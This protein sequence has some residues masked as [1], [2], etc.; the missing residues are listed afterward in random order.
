VSGKS[1]ASRGRCCVTGGWTDGAGAGGT[2]ALAQSRAAGGLDLETN[3]TID[4]DDDDQ[5]FGGD[6]NHGIIGMSGRGQDTG[7]GV[8]G[9]GAG[10][11]VAGGGA[12]GSPEQG[13]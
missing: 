11:G 2:G 4:S 5:L 1:R 3:Q 6:G 9:G 7:S 12:G 13:R 8:A 10:S